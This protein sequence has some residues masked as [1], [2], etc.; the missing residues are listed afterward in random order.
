MLKDTYIQIHEMLDMVKKAI[1]YLRNFSDEEYNQFS[2]SLEKDLEN[3]IMTINMELLDSPSVCFYDMNYQNR[4]RAPDH[5]EKQISQYEKW[6]DKITDI[7]ERRYGAKNVWDEKFFRLMDYVHSVNFEQIIENA[8]CCLKKRGDNEISSLCRYYQMFQEFWGTLDVTHN[9]YDVLQNRVTVLKEHREDFMWLYGNLGDQRSKLVLVNILYNWITFD[10]EC[11][12]KMKEANFTDYFDLDLV[13]CDDE[14]VFVDLGAWQGDST[15]NYIQTYGKY[16]KIYC[17]EIDGFNM[18]KLRVNL[19]EYSDIEYKMKGVGN[20]NYKGYLAADHSDSSCSKITDQKTDHEIEIVRLD[21][22]IKEKVTLIKMDI[23]G[24]EQDALLGCRRHIR[25]ES[26]K[27][28]I[29]VYHNNEDIWKIPRMILEMNPDYQ[30]YLRSNGAQWG[31][32]EIV[33][34]AVIDRVKD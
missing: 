24:A 28:L 26:P 23:E 12:Q 1:K 14:E 31:P 5:R 32:A 4:K 2:D 10:L 13:C 22:D 8:K 9:R 30:I 6:I 19:S 25:E 33:L 21:D 16:K 34:F 11:I 15:L 17:Y 20:R 3:T 7:L 27:L 29:S 18:Q